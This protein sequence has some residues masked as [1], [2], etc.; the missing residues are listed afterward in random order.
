MAI[1]AC[2]PSTRPLRAGPVSAQLVGAAIRHLRIGDV[3]VA[4]EIAVAVRDADWGTVPAELSAVVVKGDGEGFAVTFDASHRDADI[5]FRWRGEITGDAG[6]VRFTMNG[7][8]GTAFSYRRIGLCVLHPASTCAGRMLE[9]EGPAGAHRERLETAVAIQDE[10]DG[11]SCPLFPAYERLTISLADRFDVKFE[12]SGDLFEM[13]DQRNWTDPS[14]KSYSQW[15]A[16]GPE[17]VNARAGDAFSQSVTLSWS[18]DAPPAAAKQDPVELKLGGPLGRAVPRLGTSR[19]IGGRRLDER[20]A[21]VL[22]A[23][24]LDHIRADVHLGGADPVEEVSRGRDDARAIGAQLELALHLTQEGRDALDAVVEALSGVRLAR[25][26]V[27]ADGA[28]VTPPGAVTRVRAALAEVTPGVPV[29]GGSDLHFAELN[30]TRPD[31][32]AYDCLCFPIAPTVHADDDESVIATLAAQRAVVAT[33]AIFG[34][35]RPIAVSPISLRPRTGD[36]ELDTDPR[37]P[38]LFTAAWTVASVKA[39]A[40]AGAASSTWFETAGARGVAP[41]IAA[42]PTGTPAVAHP[43]LHCLRDVTEFRGGELLACWSSEP[44]AAQGIFMR[45]GAGA[46]VLV[47]NLRPRPTTIEI[48]P[49]AGTVVER[50][51]DTFSIR[52]ATRQ[53]AEFRAATARIEGRGCVRLTLEGHAVSCLD[54]EVP[55]SHDVDEDED[56]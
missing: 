7:A 30:R 21:A 4:H 41:S 18:G 55:N 35:G 6:H 9:A 40:E 25:V 50:V 32:R 26:L 33:A 54:I 24:C 22:A 16:A 31:P 56:E 49:I 45:R 23:A 51:L 34:E 13:E 42:A 53:P 2:A 8:A 46:R 27:F 17:P 39:F 5:D 38:G 43:V 11:I 12:F 48:G 28:A 3:E 19:P 36:P 52:R 29:G 44:S 20:E 1:E 14:F 10:I 15:P 47:A 37:Q